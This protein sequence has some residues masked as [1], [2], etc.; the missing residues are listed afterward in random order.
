VSIRNNSLAF[1]HGAAMRAPAPHDVR[2]RRA[3]ELW[4]GEDGAYIEAA[5]AFQVWT[6]DGWAV[7]LPGD[8]IVL[9][10]RGA[11]HVAHSP[12]RPADS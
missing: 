2:G 12:G 10:V 7:A 5:G 3:L 9:S 1:D 4:L 6:E 8:W 11:F